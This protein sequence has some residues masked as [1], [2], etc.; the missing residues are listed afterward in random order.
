M[1]LFSS[2]ASWQSL[3]VFVFAFECNRPI[4][5]SAVHNVSNL[6][7]G[8][9]RPRVCSF[10]LKFWQFSSE[11]TKTWSSGATECR[12]WIG[13]CNVKEIQENE[14]TPQR[15]WGKVIF[16][17]ASVILSTWGGLPQCMLGYHPRPGSRHPRTRHPPTGMHSCLT[18]FSNVKNDNLTDFSNLN[19][20]PD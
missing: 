2:R 6:K 8:Y 13:N 18:D 19:H 12:V 5:N 10:L 17:Q 7:N 11:L 9:Y 1:Y 3:F 4:G 14:H 15:S 20:L 16:S